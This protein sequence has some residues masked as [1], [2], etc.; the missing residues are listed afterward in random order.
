MAGFLTEMAKSSL[1][2]V[3]EAKTRY[4]DGELWTLAQETPVPPP[5]QLSD[6]GFDVIAELKLNS[7]AQGKLGESSDDLEG[8]VLQYAQGGAAAVSVLTEPTRFDGSMEH[9]ERAAKALAPLG[10]PAM[11][12][13]FI[14][15]PY[16]VVES[17]VAGAGGVLVILRMIDRR[18][19][20]ELLDCAAMLKLFVLLEGF[21]EEDLALGA[22]IV[23]ERRLHDEKILLGLNARNLDTLQVVP[24][25]LKDL[26][27]KLAA[28]VPHVAESGVASPADTAALAAAGYQLA[29]IGTALMSTGNPRGL[30]AEM[31]KAARKW[32]HS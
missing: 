28:G 23:A 8:R 4:T 27:P 7:P 15:D 18:R 25:R 1:A 10:V 20:V 2:R 29:L 24:E 26:A 13:D 14:F 16:Q 11:R 31:L 9:L 3:T 5:L 22:E 32:G 17:R 30:I 19:I 21:D 6:A 12:K